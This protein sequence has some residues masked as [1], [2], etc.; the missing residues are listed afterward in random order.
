MCLK[1]E[2]RGVALHLPVKRRLAVGVDDGE[3]ELPGE[4]V[5]RSLDVGD[6]QF[7]RDRGDHGARGGL[8]G[9]V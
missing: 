9:S 4:E 6:E 8:R 5:A 3:A 2:P 1:I 7:G